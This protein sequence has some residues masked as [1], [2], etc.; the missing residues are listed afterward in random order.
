MAR[1]AARQTP[2][3]STP[4][5]PQAAQPAADK[6]PQEKKGLLHR[7]FGVFK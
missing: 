3:D 2:P 4:A 7:I 1:R 6:K 5:Q